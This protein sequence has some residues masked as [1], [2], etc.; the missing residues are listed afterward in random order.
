MAVDPISDEVSAW[1]RRFGFVSFK[2]GG[3]LYMPVRKARELVSE[4]SDGFFMFAS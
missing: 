3:R 2:D 1:Y 4:Q